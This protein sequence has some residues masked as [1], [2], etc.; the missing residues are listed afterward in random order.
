M[1]KTDQNKLSPGARERLSP[2]AVGIVG[3]FHQRVLAILRQAHPCG[4]PAAER[5]MPAGEACDFCKDIAL[6]A[7]ESFEV[8]VI[9]VCGETPGRCVCGF[10]TTPVGS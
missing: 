9:V 6:G 2:F 4:L 7:T 10:H 1:R 5:G 8:E 3:L